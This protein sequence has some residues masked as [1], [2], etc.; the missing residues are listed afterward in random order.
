MLAQAARMSIDSVA[1]RSPD[2]LLASLP[3]LI[4]FTPA[5]SVVVVW[6]R[7]SAIVLTQ[8]MD[9]PI[10]SDPTA[11]QQ[12]LVAPAA[13]TDA[14]EVVV[15]LVRPC[16]DAES[17]DVPARLVGT[18][19]Q[20]ACRLAAMPVRDLL[21]LDEGRW[22]SLMCADDACCPAVG[23][24]LDDGVQVAVAAEFAAAGHAPLAA[25]A[26]VVASLAFDAATKD[27]L[28]GRVARARPPR[29]DREA[30]RDRTIKAFVEAVDQAPDS[31]RDDRASAGAIAGLGDIRVRDT[32]LWE[33]TRRDGDALGR[34][35][36][37][38]I[39]SLRGCPP[40]D[41]PG[42]ATTLAVVAWL[43]GD[44]ARA[45]I[46]LERALAVDPQYSLAHLVQ[47]SISSGLP[48]R[49]WVEAMGGLSR[50][51]CRHGD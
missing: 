34:A 11:W 2:A 20:D 3:Y 14:D 36:V 5:D 8:R 29:A 31:A 16:G 19:V 46:A 51:A 1:L 4:G 43:L 27:R 38:L 10:S 39:T 32:V 45:M 42:A 21:H 24:V 22:R 44:G 30:W 23:R 47:R 7:G 48:P 6:L 25:R 40:S 49:A 33:L 12:A 15:V 18:W 13:T 50:R 9:W 37:L 41:V 35:L 26:D 28:D 17:G